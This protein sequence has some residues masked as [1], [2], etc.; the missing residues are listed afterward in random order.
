MQFKELEW[1]DITSDG[2]IACST[3]ELSICGWIKIEFR[4]NHESKENKYYLYSFG[5]GGIR[6]LEP[7]KYDSVESAKNAAY[8]IYSNEMARI[9]KAVDFLIYTES[10]I[11]DD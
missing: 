8:R 9:K 11:E 1:K 7:V 10:S 4:I 6:R 5:K 2:V 3:C